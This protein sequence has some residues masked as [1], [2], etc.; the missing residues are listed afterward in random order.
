MEALFESRRALRW[1]SSASPTSSN[2]SIDNPIF[3]PRVLSYLAYR[4]WGANMQ[5]L[6]AFPRSEWPD[7]IPLLYF[8]YHIMV[9][10][11]TIF[12]AV[13]V[14]CGLAAVAKRLFESRWMLWILLL[15]FP[16][17]LHR[18]HRRLDDGRDRP[19]AVSG[20]RLAAHRQR[21]FANRCRRATDVHAARFPGNVY[22]LSILFL[23]LIHRE[24]EHGPERS[25][26]A[27]REWPSQRDHG[28]EIIMPTLW[29][30]I[31]AVM[32]VV[33][34]FSTASTSAPA[35]FTDR[36]RTDE[37]A[38]AGDPLHRPGVGWQRS[39]AAGRRRRALFRLPA[40][41]R[42]QLQ[43]LLPAADDGALAA[44]AARHRHRVPHTHRARMSG[45][46]SSTPCSPWPACCWRSF[47]EPRWAT[48][49]AA[50]RSARITT[51]FCRCSP[52]GG[53][54]RN[55]AFWIGTPFFQACW[56]WWRSPA[57]VRT[58]SL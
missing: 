57:T 36:A 42:L 33:T 10:L 17:P 34:W 38:Q 51:S 11:G 22:L 39:L 30:C 3:V 25:G 2:R 48:W 58:T 8:S 49:C 27:E 6:D 50:F 44:D 12:M 29:F 46:H 5:G 24:I 41:L 55:P 23:F 20:L 15:S 43:R 26:R 53:W 16:L 4:D 47:T 37:R 32:L 19:P 28:G 9:G 7:N 52:T 31:V 1:S 54:G 21:L 13:M 35:P 45:N 40:A 56:H 14:D 18:Q